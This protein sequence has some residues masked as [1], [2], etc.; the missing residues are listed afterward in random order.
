MI[1]E[2]L[3]KFLNF[4]LFFLLAIS[5]SM[6]GFAIVLAQ[7]F[8]FEGF[9]DFIEVEIDFLENLPSSYFLVPLIYWN[10]PLLI[11]LVAK[12]IYRGSPNK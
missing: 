12:Y 5:L 8:L 11:V 7:F 6:V 10:I 4:R 1:F 3:L 9:L 2:R